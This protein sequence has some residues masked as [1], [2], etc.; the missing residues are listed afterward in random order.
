MNKKTFYL[1]ILP[2]MLAGCSNNSGN[3]NGNDNNKSYYINEDVN[4]TFLCMADSRY[5]SKLKVMVDEFMQSEPHVKVNLSNPLGSGDYSTVE[6]NVIAGF[7]NGSYPDIVQCYPDN[8]VKYINRGYALK[9]DHYLDNDEYGIFENNQTDYIQAFLDEGSHYPGIEGSYSLPF[10]KSTELMYYNKDA[11]I[12]LGLDGINDG[13]PLDATYLDNLTWEELFN[14]L[15]PA[16]KAKN[17]LLPDNEKLYI[18]S[19][20]SAIFTYD[21][22][23]NLFI[24]LANQYGYGYTSVDEEGNPSIDFDNPEMKALTKSLKSA[25]DNGYLHTRG[26]SGNYVSYLFQT[27]K[28]LF[29]VSSTAGLKYNLPE[30]DE[31][32]VGVARI[33]HA[34]GKEYSAI[35]Q[36]PSVCILDHNDDLRALASYLLW[37]YITNEEN[38][39]VWAAFTGYMG[40]RASSYQSDEYRKALIV[41]ENSSLEEKAVA[42]N[43]KKISEVSAYTFNTDVF[44]GSSNARKN[45]GELLTDCLKYD[46]VLDDDTINALF[47]ESSNEVKTHL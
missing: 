16:I 14:N 44:K 30:H 17:D 24:T 21:S 19:S 7:F 36:G 1:F 43:L 37:R 18:S 41:D 42:E 39:T 15:C 5:I 38:S 20:D 46:G 31:F 35:N 25:K 22:S 2:F 3:Q 27:R 34:E 32:E 47:L 33:P 26:S 23:E 11:L 9:L 28:S 10:C 12:G 40:I 8:V 29:T 4:I 6:R 45:V 13:N